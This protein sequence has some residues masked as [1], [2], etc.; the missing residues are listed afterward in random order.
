MLDHFANFRHQTLDRRHSILCALLVI[1]FLCTESIAGTADPDVRKALARSAGFSAD[2]I[3]AVERGEPVTK[4][5]QAN[6][7]REVAVC[8]AIELPSE[9]ESALKAFQ[10]SLSLKQKSVLAS[11]KF[12][13]LPRLEDLGS[14][15]LSDG[16]I[17]DLKMCTVGKCKLKLSAAMIQRF[18]RNID[19]NAIDYKE[20]INQL[21]RLVLLEYVTAYLQRGD[22]A[23]IEYAD[24]DARVSLAREQESLLASLPYLN[25]VVPEFVRDLKAFPQSSA[26]VEHSLSWANINFGLKPVVVIT[27]TATYRPA[28]DGVPRLVVLAKQIYA[29]HYFDASLSMTALI[30]DRSGTTSNLLYVNRSRASSLA[31]LFSNFKHQI[32]E[33]RAIREVNDLLGQTR[34]N[35][36]VVVNNS[37][38]SSQPTW[39]ERSTQTPF[40]LRILGWSV[41]FKLIGTLL[42]FKFRSKLPRFRKAA[43]GSQSA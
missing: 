27:D 34:L 40:I 23:L 13:E 22:A 9:P 38:L 19:W 16:D 18:Q 36:D 14:L 10:L 24:Q 1:L 43:P 21:F 5:I 17:D 4:L 41:L 31:S 7:P 28:V 29:N 8:G 6:D 25:E 11:G 42:F 3:A 15:T 32:V 12:S 30:G 35:V 39:A 37:S 33:G 20:Q 26:S 2:E